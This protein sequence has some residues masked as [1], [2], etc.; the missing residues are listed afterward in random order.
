MKRLFKFLPPF[1]PDYSGVCSALFE[2]GGI[3]VILDASGCTGNYTGYDEPRW[4]GGPGNVYCSGLREMDAVLGDEAKLFRK[5][6]EYLGRRRAAFIALLGSPA[7]MVIG[8]DYAAVAAEMA[9]QFDLPV[10]AFA[11]SGMHYYDQGASQALL[12]V[13]RQFV[14]PPSRKAADGVNIIGATPLDLSS[15]NLQALR[16]ELEKA[17]C[18]IVSCWS[19]GSDLAAIGRA[20]EAG[21]NLVVSGTGLAAARY[22]ESQYGIPFMTGIPVG[23]L[24]GSRLLNTI[25]SG[26][27]GD[28]V[29]VPAPLPAGVDPGPALVIGEQVTANSIRRCLQDDF[30]FQRVDVASYF[31]LDAALLA[32]GD[33]YLQSEDDLVELTRAGGYAVVIGDPLYQPLVQAARPQ[34]IGIPHYAVSSKIFH[35]DRRCYLGEEGNA[36]IAEG[37]E[38]VLM[39]SVN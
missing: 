2:L 35:M 14:K 3:S 34:Y 27:S 36:M 29:Q 17:G 1:A 25:R 13:A 22:L 32:A 21:L 31:N 15:A 30:G 20:A 19:M 33:R 4:Y 11:T 10:L 39:E 16:R 18:S 26:R 38:R 7:P 6:Q 9:Q 24:A 5:V 37:F 28:V 23:K 12:A 8:M